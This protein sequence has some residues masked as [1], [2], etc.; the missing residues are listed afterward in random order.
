M[1]I[2]A[3]LPMAKSKYTKPVNTN[4]LARMTTWVVSFNKICLKRMKKKEVT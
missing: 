1:A 3:R 2:L 4:N